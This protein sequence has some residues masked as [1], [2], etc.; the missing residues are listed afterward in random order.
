MCLLFI[1]L[2]WLAV[3][4]IKKTS[5]IKNKKISEWDFCFK[6][7]CPAILF[8]IFLLVYGF[9]TSRFFSIARNFTL[10]KISLKCVPGTYHN[11][12]KWRVISLKVCFASHLHSRPLMGPEFSTF[13]TS[14]ISIAK[15]RVVPL[16]HRTSSPS[17]DIVSKL[18]LTNFCHK[19]V[20]ANDW[21]P[22]ACHSQRHEKK[23]GSS[24]EKS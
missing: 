20:S 16:N 13:P 8:R 10:F 2:Y 11:A 7:E 6:I 14:R 4:R 12:I 22:Q 23:K 3:M 15:I 24:R 19:A 18:L 21:N 1:S 9:I 17:C 5:A